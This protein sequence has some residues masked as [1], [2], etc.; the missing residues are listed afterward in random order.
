ME[1]TGVQMV[2]P[3]SLDAGHGS[4]GFTVSL[5][6]LDHFVPEIFQFFFS[7]IYNEGIHCMPLHIGSAYLDYFLFVCYTR[8]HS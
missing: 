2:T 3:L 6:G 8:A 4:S 7:F 1:P 5:Q